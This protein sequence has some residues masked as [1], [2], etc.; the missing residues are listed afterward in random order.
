MKSRTQVLIA[1]GVPI[2][3]A[4]VVELLEREPD[5][6]VTQADSLQQ[7]LAVAADAPP[8]V[9]LV[10][11]DLPAGGGLEAVRFLVRHRSVPVIVWSLDPSRADVLAA[12]RAGAAGY[13]RKKV[14]P[15]GLVRSLR[16]LQ[17]GEAPIARDLMQPVIAELYERP[18]N[19]HVHNGETPLSTRQLEV[20]E[21][22]ARGERNGVI[23]GELGISEFT[24]KRHLQNIRAKL[25]LESR[26]AAAAYFRRAYGGPFATNGAV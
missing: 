14:S 4:G 23:A 13:L 17:G 12:V 21:L 9:A 26:D 19:G 5:F 10:D 7:L 3:R 1:E 22:V 11:R 18:R 2:F 15:L 24:V 20:L 8:D 16:G 25:E 6:E